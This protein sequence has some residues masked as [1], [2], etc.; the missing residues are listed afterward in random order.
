MSSELVIVFHNFRNEQLSG[1]RQ[2]SGPIAI[3]FDGLPEKAHQLLAIGR[4]RIERLALDRRGSAE[5]V[6]FTEELHNGSF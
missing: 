3:P 4:F 5:R 1:N 2:S 6:Q